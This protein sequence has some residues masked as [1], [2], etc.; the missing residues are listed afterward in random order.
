MNYI[1]KYAYYTKSAIHSIM[2]YSIDLRKRVLSFIE[3]GGSI[4]DASRRFSVSRSIIY[5]WINAD[6]PFTYQ[7][8]GPRKP[9]SLDPQLLKQH[10]L[11]FPD[12][13]LRERASYFGVSPFCVWYGLKNIGY[14]YKKRN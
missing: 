12:H 5:K 9:R 11:D 1:N 3:T 6:D 14:T 7:K 4:T 13:S 8:P 2:R 10:V